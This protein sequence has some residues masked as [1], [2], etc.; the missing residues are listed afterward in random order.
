MPG[1]TLVSSTHSSAVCV[2]EHQVDAREAVAAEQLDRPRPPAPAP[3][4]RD[5]RRQLGRAHERRHA[6]LVARLVVVEVL[7]ARA[8]PRRSAARSAGALGAAPSVRR[9]RT[10]R[11]RARA[12]SA[13]SGSCGRRRTRRPSR[14][15]APSLERANLTPRAEPPRGGLDDQREA[16][17]L[18]DAPAAPRAAP[19][20]LIDGLAQRV[21]VGRRDP[22]LAHQVLGE[23]LV[24]AAHAR[25]RARSRVGQAE[26]LQQRP[27]RCRPRPRGRA[28][29]RT[30]RRA[31]ARAAARRASVPTSIAT[32]SWPRPSSAS[33]TCAPERSETRALER[34]AALEHGDPPAR[35]LID[36]GGGAPARRPSRRGS[37]TTSASCGVGAP[38]RPRAGAGSRA[39]AARA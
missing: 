39:G 26:R 5:L 28:A 19:R 29:R 31:R 14:R 18:L 24:G 7:L 8:P 34:A 9:A 32:T 6:D 38:A 17:P 35:P 2:V 11:G 15:A 33:C 30:R 25:G 1:T 12:R 21:E 37:A 3:A 10:R 22:R 13:R 4:R 16:E 27:A 23:R 36:P 20:S